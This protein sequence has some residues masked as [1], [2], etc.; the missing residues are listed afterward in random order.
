VRLREKRDGGHY[1]VRAVPAGR[2][3][4]VEL[5]EVGPDTGTGRGALRGGSPQ[6]RFGCYAPGGRHGEEVNES[7]KD[8]PGL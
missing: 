4:Y 1:R 8:T 7:L 5:P 2:N 6:S 3:R